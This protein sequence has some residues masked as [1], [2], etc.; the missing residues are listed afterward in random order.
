MNYVVYGKM[1]ETAGAF[2]LAYVGVRAGVLEILIGQH[3]QRRKETGSPDL[4]ALRAGLEDVL[5][6]RKR[7][8][9]FYEA[10]AVGA[11]TLL[12]AIGCALYLVGL[13]TQGHHPPQ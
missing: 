3:L 4:E 5:D 1:L 2:L 12:I 13:L 7:Q 11:G 10:I 8:F 9:G 6:R